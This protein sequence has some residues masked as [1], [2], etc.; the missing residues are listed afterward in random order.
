MIPLHNKRYCIKKKDLIDFEGL[1]E[2]RVFKLTFLLSFYFLMLRMV[3]EAHTAR[4]LVLD[5]LER[6]PSDSSSEMTDEVR[7]SFKFCGRSNAVQISPRRPQ[8]AP[9]RESVR[10]GS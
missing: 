1:R 8:Q 7:A 5:S 10:S 6:R 2:F 3:F 4:V 9:T